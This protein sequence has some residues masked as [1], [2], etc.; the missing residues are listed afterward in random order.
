MCIRDSI[1][2]EYG[3]N[4]STT[5]A[6]KQSM[7][8][9]NFAE[10]SEAALNDQI[11][12]ELYASYAYQAAARHFE[13]EDV[14]LF[15]FAKFFQH[16]SDE[17]REHAEKFQKYLLLRGGNL[18]LKDIKAPPT[19]YESGLSA[20]EAALQL[21]RDVNESLLNMHKVA[22]E[23]NDSQMTDFLEGNY[24]NEQVESIKELS[25]HVTNLK[26]VGPGLGEYLF[27][28]NTLDGGDQLKL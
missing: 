4:P 22:D 7:C 25:D 19:S 23:S 3:D 14:A 18:V 2:A 24:L 20:M 26:R 12:M 8:R 6:E 17:E 27:D 5:M 9:Q 10:A 28:K 15:G 11:N 1:N 16:S 21:E 13:R